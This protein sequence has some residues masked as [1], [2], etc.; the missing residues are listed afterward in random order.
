MPNSEH[1]ARNMQDNPQAKVFRS[2]NPDTGVPAPIFRDR[3]IAAERT[4]PND[5]EA[6]TRQHLTESDS[7]QLLGYL[8]DR[9]GGRVTTAS[10]GL[11]N[12]QPLKEWA[13]EGKKPENSQL[14]D[15]KVRVLFQVTYPLALTYSVNT[16]SAWLAQRSI[17]LDGEEPLSVLADDQ[18]VNKPS[19]GPPE[20]PKKGLNVSVTLLLL[21]VGFLT[22][23][24]L[25]RSAPGSH[26]HQ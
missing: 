21:C 16:A 23:G 26:L 9:L 1:P 13:A 10:L 12:A 11:T 18:F 22:D 2:G 15:H 20:R 5:P 8:L 19:Q 25:G 3:L 7:G 4:G 24:K 6:M 14:L 17:Y